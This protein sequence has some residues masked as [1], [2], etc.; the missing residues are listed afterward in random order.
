MV[1]EKS[2]Q[3][4]AAALPDVSMET[5]ELVDRACRA[6]GLGAWVDLVIAARGGTLFKLTFAGRRP[7]DF[8]KE[9]AALLRRHGLGLCAD[10]ALD[11]YMGVPDALKPVVATGRGVPAVKLDDLGK[12]HE[13]DDRTVAI[14]GAS[15]S[16]G[17]R[18]ERRGSPLELEGVNVLVLDD[19]EVSRKVIS[20][21]LKRAGS[22]VSVFGEAEAAFALLKQAPPDIVVL[23][24]VLG[25]ALDG[26]EFCRVM[27]T[28]EQC[29][30]VPA[31]FVTGQAGSQSRA[32][33]GDV[34]ASAFL[35]KPI[36][37]GLLCAAIT[38]L[39]RRMTATQ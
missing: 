36:Q 29:A 6:A 35:E 23:D 1:R 34:R 30:Q 3:A 28:S 27:R 38:G 39:A 7:V 37:G 4:V 22:Q 14:S 5:V 10:S 2:N 20:A 17:I 18:Y 25:G 33:A 11:V 13:A 9:F 21:M 26:F 32:R 15:R 12:L 8:I 31:I 24:V 16:A 19:D